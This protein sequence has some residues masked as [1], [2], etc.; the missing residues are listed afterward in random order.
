MNKWEDFRRYRDL[1][2][3]LALRDVKMRYQLT[4]LGL[5]WAIINPLLTALIMGFIFEKIFRASGLEGVPYVI[6]LFTGLT[7]WNLFANSVTTAANCLTGQAA[8]LSKQYFP[9][10]ILP[11]ASVLARFVDMLLS[12]VAVF[13]ILYI[14]DIS[15]G[16]YAWQIVGLLIIQLIFTLGMSFLVSSLNVLFRDVSQ[17]VTILLAL[18]MYLSPIFYS[19]NQIP[20]DLSF[21]NYILYNAIGQI[22]DMERNALLGG[23]GLNLDIL[24]VSFGISCATF[25]FGYVVFKR[26]EPLIAEVM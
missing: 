4:V 21:K 14:Y 9:R 10:I 18:W 2:I 5:Y 20:G 19:F 22:V 23:P 11:I 7:F 12:M 6:Y 25:F 15:V 17:I 13:I 26:I 8:L 16:P 3:A 24:L 1:V